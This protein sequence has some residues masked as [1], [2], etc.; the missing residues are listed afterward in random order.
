MATISSTFPTLVDVTKRLD[1]TGGIAYVAEVMSK[2]NPI[3]EDMAWSEGN[4]PTGHRY[5]ARAA[6][7]GVGSGLVWRRFNQGVDPG[8]SKTEQ[9][10]ETCGMLEGYSKVDVDLAKLNGNE[11]A[12][13]LSE[14]QAFI[15]GMNIEV[16]NALFYYN[17]LT[18]AERPTGL[19]PRLNSISGVNDITNP[20]AVSQ[21][22]V[23]DASAAGANQTSIWLIGWSP[24]T[25]FGIFPKGSVSGIQSEDLGRQLILDSNNKQFLAFV[26]RWQWKLGLCVR[27]FRYVSRCCNIDVTRWKEDFSQG[28][29]IAMRMIDQMASIY[30]LQACRPV[31]YMNR[32]TYNMLNKQLV[33]RQAN[34]LEFLVGPDGRRIPAFMGI[35]IKYVDAITSTESVV[36]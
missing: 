12:F 9:Y 19:T 2:F 36:S 21:L 22:V 28:A 16:A 29:D 6:L 11:A 24:E 15:Q 20:M 35:P 1:P 7:P 34:W 33:K 18:N 3:L 13:R 32:A 4:L 30:N 5:T 23:G 8:V 27:D 10:D 14:D 17:S 25:V 31:Y 26:T